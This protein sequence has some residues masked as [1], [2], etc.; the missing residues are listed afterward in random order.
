MMRHMSASAWMCYTLI[1]RRTIGWHKC[2]DVISNSQFCADTGLSKAT[3]IR[4]LKELA[5]LGAVEMTP[6]KIHGQP[7][8]QYTVVG[9]SIDSLGSIE[10]IPPS[11]KSIPPSAKLIPPSIKIDTEVV[12]K[13]YTQKKDIQKKQIKKEREGAPKVRD[14]ALDSWQVITYQ[15]IAK[16]H[17]PVTWRQKV[18]DTVTDEHKWKSLLVQWIGS[19]WNIGNI[20]GILQRYEGA[21]HERRATRQN[22]GGGKSETSGGLT[23]AQYLEANGYPG[24]Q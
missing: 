10:F 18:I 17:I 9:L 14:P 16:R 20:S 8:N 22:D 7:A 3:V 5:T 13:L 1:C 11:I 21:H 23:V 6:T 15:Q 19:G 2:A 4:A 24:L 12:S